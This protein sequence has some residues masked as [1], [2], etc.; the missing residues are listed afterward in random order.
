MISTQ[1]ISRSQPIRPLISIIV[2]CYNVERFLVECL[3]SIQNQTYKNIEIICVNDGSC[4]GTVDIIKSFNKKDGRF[5]LVDKNNTG[6]GDSVNVGISVA[7]GKYI[8]IIESDDYIESKMFEELLLVAE[9]NKCDVVKCGYFLT[10]KSQELE[11]FIKRVSKNKVFTPLEEKNLFFAPPA[12][13]SGLYLKSFLIDNEI[14]FL[15]TPGAS[16]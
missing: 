10:F 9:K 1:Q 16:Y 14:K 6:Y 13:W 3:T 11:F 5:I 12:I 8:G 4:D 7:N 15:A 2:P